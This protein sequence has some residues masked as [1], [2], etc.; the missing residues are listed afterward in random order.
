MKYVINDQERI[1]KVHLE[2]TDKD[3][4]VVVVN[5]WQVIRL[6]KYGQ[7]ERIEDISSDMGLLVDSEG[8]IIIK[9]SESE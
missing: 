1:L 3:E 6:T 9:N 2:L 7:L 4:C 8:R 5:D